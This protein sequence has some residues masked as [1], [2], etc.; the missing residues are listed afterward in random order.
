[1]RQVVKNYA[2]GELLTLFDELNALGEIVLFGG[3]LRDLALRSPSN[4][5]S[6]VDLVVVT[7]S[8][9]TFDEFF[10]SRNARINRFG[11]Y[12]IKLSHGSVD[13]WPL[14]RTWAFRT[15]AVHGSSPGDL[16]RTTYFSW[17]SIAYSWRTGRIFCRPTYL[18]ELRSRIV[19]LELPDNPYPLGALVRTLRLLVSRK[20]GVS[21]RLARHTYRLLSLYKPREIIKAEQRGFSSPYLEEGV[22]AQIFD[23]LVRFILQTE[24]SASVFMLES[25]SQLS[26]PFLKNV[27]IHRAIASADDPSNENPW[28][29][30]HQLKVG[31]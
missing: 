25:N 2:Q 27:P 15:G 20:A 19:D 5:R 3:V 8:E 18:Q 12:R 16:L 6:D 4:F 30:S 14:H 29:C 23:L 22:V 9:Q 21:L 17:D 7:S 28:E 10:N 13:V 11:G 24:G 31:G 26:L 1:M